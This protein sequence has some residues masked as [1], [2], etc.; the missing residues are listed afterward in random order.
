MIKTTLSVLQFSTNDVQEFLNNALKQTM[1]YTNSKIG[2]IYFRQHNEDFSTLCFLLDKSLEMNPIKLFQTKHEIQKTPLWKHIIQSKK[3]LINNDLA[4]DDV[5]NKALT[6]QPE[7]LKNIVAIPVFEKDSLVLLLLLANAKTGYLTET[8]EQ[9]A[10]LMEAAWNRQ[11]SQ[12]SVSR[13][14]KL[15]TVLTGIRSVNQLI[16]QEPDPAKL[17]RQSCEKIARSFAYLN[18]WILLV[19][20]HGK[21]TDFAFAGDD[22]YGDKLEMLLK[23]N[24][25]PKCVKLAV[26]SESLVLFNKKDSICTE[27][28]F[29]TD[30]ENSAAMSFALRSKGKLFGV[31]T[32][33]VPI[34]FIS[35]PR[36][37]ELFMELANDIAFALYK[38]DIEAERKHLRH[39]LSERIKEMECTLAVSNEIQKDYT[40]A[41]FF[42][43]LIQAIRLGFSY[44]DELKVRIEIGDKVVEDQ[45]YKSRQKQLSAM[46]TEA[47]RQCGMIEV[48][49]L[50][51]RD[52][53][54]PEEQKL[55]DI[56]AL[57]VSRWIEKKRANERLIRSE[58]NLSI[59]LQS[60][61]DGVLATDSSGRIKRMN[62]VAEN[63]IGVTLKEAWNKPVSEVFNIVNADSRE[64]IINPVEKV[65]KTGRTVGLSN[66]TVL[67]SAKGTEYQ[68]RDSAAPIRNK[69]NEIEGMILVFSDVTTQYKHQASIA[70]SQRKFKA[71]F[72]ATP[73]AVSITE[74]ATGKYIDVNTAFET[75]FEYQRDELIGKTSLEIYIWIDAKDRKE[76]VEKLKN[77]KQIT[78][79]QTN[80]RTKSGRII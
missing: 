47:D 8:A 24:E 41:V 63:L 12:K 10:L 32:A 2:C 1:L 50:E 25:I 18:C 75:M 29:V 72:N 6:Q 43:K 15:E 11:K 31:I 30:T 7:L 22:D 4:A 46:L 64:R 67:I 68:I 62:K 61:G 56:I 45:W 38:I 3:V 69:K 13:E 54:L 17:I 27:C 58:E 79:Y 19:D 78:N 36:E 39:N 34:A 60:I 26:E 40:E 51:D 59:T 42:E 71:F 35:L 9:L 70:E 48:V 73:G 20:E 5:L 37:Q 44:P 76:F 65:L 57:M 16:V 74:I 66:H 77:E 14:D 80:F 33:W 23:N 55:L 49:Y 21:H 53:I 52:F 28:G